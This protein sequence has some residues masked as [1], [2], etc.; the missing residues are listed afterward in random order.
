MRL[1]GLINSVLLRPVGDILFEQGLRNWLR[2]NTKCCGK[3]EKWFRYIYVLKYGSSKIW[4]KIFRFWSDLKLLAK[5][6][7][8][9][10]C[11][12]FLHMR[13]LLRKLIRQIILIGNE[14]CFIQI[15]QWILENFCDYTP[16][17]VKNI[18]DG[19]G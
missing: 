5:Y 12:L 8:Y 2:L 9:F 18:S 11:N 16:F 10:V 15:Y 19:R 17:L 6:L 14:K 1:K 7:W 4:W 3:F 13:Y